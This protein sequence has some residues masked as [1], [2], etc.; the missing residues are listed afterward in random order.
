MP[1][2]IV[3]TTPLSPALTASIKTAITALHVLLDV[4]KISLSPAQIKGLYKIGAIKTSEISA[5]FI[6]LMQAHPETIPS[7]FTLADFIALTQEGVDCVTLEAMFLALAA[8]VG[9]HGEI[10]QNDRMFW[11]L[12][13]LDNA[14]LI[15]K[16]VPAV[17]EIVDELGTEFFKKAPS[18]KIATV[19]TIAPAASITISGVVSGKYFTNTG[20]TI[21]TILKVGAL[22]S[23]TITINPGSGV[24]ILAY[25]TKI[26]V[27]N[28][29]TVSAGA[30]SLFIQA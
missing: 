1:Q 13:C 25:W 11:G 5:I 9:G 10:V 24:K 12:Q 18:T 3:I 6:K 2:E 7:S 19:Y 4:I 27:T 30:F 28:V 15:G 23:E 17:Q 29:S 14:R 8:I 22:V 26:V 21:L 16:T 20:T